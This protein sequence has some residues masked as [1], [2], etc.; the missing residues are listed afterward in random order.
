MIWLVRSPLFSENV[1]GAGHRC[2]S[3]FGKDVFIVGDGEEVEKDVH[4]AV[5]PQS[6]PDFGTG[7]GMAVLYD[8]Y[9]SF[10]RQT[11]KLG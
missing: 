3:E 9:V 7:K 1:G 5:S 10:P 11:L 8:P 2:G 4:T 6:P